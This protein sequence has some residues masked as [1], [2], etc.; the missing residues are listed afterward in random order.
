[1]EA[2][3]LQSFHDQL[4]SGQSRRGRKGGL[5]GVAGEGGG[6]KGSQTF[7]GEEGER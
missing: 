5:G 1:M 3:K 4:K 6:Q 2:E 7:F